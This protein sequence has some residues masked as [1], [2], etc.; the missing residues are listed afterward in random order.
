MNRFKSV[1]NKKKI[2]AG[3][4]R[5]PKKTLTIMSYGYVMHDLSSQWKEHIQN[6][7]G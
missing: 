3:F 1:E 5:S 7:W 2:Y 4:D 6:Y